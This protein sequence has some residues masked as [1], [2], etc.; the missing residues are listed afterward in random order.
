[1]NCKSHIGKWKDQY[2][3]YT[4]IGDIIENIRIK[5]GFAR[6]VARLNDD[7]W[8]KTVWKDGWIKNGDPVK[9]REAE[10]YHQRHEQTT[11]KGV[12]PSYIEM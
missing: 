9:I 7:R 12:C 5:W 10:E 3:D 11:Y 2:Q 4:G 8:T 6:H 1:M